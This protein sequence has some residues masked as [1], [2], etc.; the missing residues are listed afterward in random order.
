MISSGAKAAIG[1]AGMIGSTATLNF[2]KAVDQGIGAINEGL[3]IANIL[4]KRDDMD[5]LPPQ[6]SGMPSTSLAYT[7]DRKICRNY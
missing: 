2:G 3:S 4:A 5:R 1:I 6:T 7:I